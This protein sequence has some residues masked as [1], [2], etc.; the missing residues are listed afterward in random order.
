MWRSVALVVT[1]L[2]F[3]C[4][5]CG[6]RAKS[7]TNNPTADAST[8]LGWTFGGDAQDV[9]DFAQDRA[10]RSYLAVNVSSSG[11]LQPSVV[12]LD[13]EGH[14][15]W[16]V[17]LSEGAVQ[18]VIVNGTGDVWVRGA[19][20]VSR[21]SAAGSL[22]WSVPLPGASA[23]RG[24]VAGDGSSYYYYSASGSAQVSLQAFTADGSAKWSALLG[25][26]TSRFDGAHVTS[27]GAPAIDSQGRV[28]VP[29]APCANGKA[30]VTGLDPKSGEPVAT[31]AVDMTDPSA[32]VNTLH[33]VTVD[34][35]GNIY[36]G[37]GPN[38][39]DPTALA[40]ADAAGK[41]RWTSLAAQAPESS[42][43]APVLVGGAALSAS[44]ASGLVELAPTDASVLARLG[45]PDTGPLL[46][47]LAGGQRLLAKTFSSGGSGL[48]TSTEGL[49]VVDAS[50]V[51]VFS[52]ATLPA[53][54]ALVGRRLIFGI[55]QSAPT[56]S[57]K[58]SAVPA[59]VD[60]LESSPW[61]MVGHDLGRT[62]SASG[63]W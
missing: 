47:L 23:F 52:E 2:C 30:G 36:Y 15:V 38:F 10:G 31:A 61:P 18:S 53:A 12:A 28:Y 56:G 13:P 39:A 6:G 54:K 42:A 59:V 46:A 62:N 7:S 50:G 57:G 32:T 26:N 3:S 24:A 29:C 45:V 5:A 4:S 44:T 14:E 19:S 16:R 41:L 9:V 22:R 49:I 58:L 11:T 37:Y 33:G 34:G 51:T 8:K 40:S 27:F 1:V 60:G 55:V 63:A 17:T 43:L 35:T 21:I 20:S 25:G 48:S